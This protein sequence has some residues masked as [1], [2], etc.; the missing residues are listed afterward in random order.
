MEKRTNKLRDSYQKQLNIFTE[1]KEKKEA[2]IEQQILGAKQKI[3]RLEKHVEKLQQT[4]ITSKTNDFE[5]FEDFLQ[6]SVKDSQQSQQNKENSAQP[7]ETSSPMDPVNF[8]S[9]LG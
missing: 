4:L 5:S 2:N 1:A 9:R 3:Y 7:P 8:F 6:R